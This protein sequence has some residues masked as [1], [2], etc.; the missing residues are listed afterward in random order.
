[1]GRAAHLME[2]VVALAHNDSIMKITALTIQ[3]VLVPL[4]E[5]HRTA[6]GVVAA[7]PLVLLTVSTDAGVQGQSIL[8]TYAPAALKPTAELVKGMEA[9]IVG[10][11]LAPAALWHTLHARFRLLGTQGLVG[12][13]LAGIDMAL[14]DALARANQQPLYALLGAQAKPIKAYGAVGYD[15]VEGSARV[16]EAWA[17]KGF[18]G[19][20]AK[21]GYPTLAE[22]IATIRAMR[23]AV[24]PDV[25]IM[26][27]Y[28][29][30]L[31]PTDAA[32]RLAA[33]DQ[34]GLAW[35]EEPVLAHDYTAFVQLAQSTR[36]PLQAGENWWGPLD[37]RQ[38]FNAGMRELVMPDV[39]KCGGVTGWQQIAA[40]ASVYG[41]PLSNHLW[42]EISTHLL[43]AT[44]TAHWLEYADWWNPILKEPLRIEQGMAQ[45]SSAPGSG[46]E[47]DEAAVQRY[48]A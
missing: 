23:Q 10:Q 24:G 38:A 29:Q 39:M 20:K 43:C 40:M 26:V 18:K 19:V 17:K 14:W 46:I 3:T 31:P 9:L 5:P 48:T 28:N 36:T 6:S 32:Q 44:P 37:F 45:V 33:L 4:P 22:D 41:V 35:I 34:E 21:I 2:A 1:M 15:G 27:D 30:S 42:P 16:A 11:E 13:A 25:A 47:F 12:M 8:F 7:S